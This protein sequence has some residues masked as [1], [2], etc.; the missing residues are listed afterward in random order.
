MENW[1]KSL[2]F[3]FLA[4]NLFALLCVSCVDEQEYA[5]GGDVKLAFGC[6]TL[7]FDTIFT[8]VGSTTKTVMVYNNEDKPILIERISLREGA[9]SFFKLNVD[10][11]VSSVVKNVEVGAKDSLYIF[12][13]VELNPNNQSNP[14][15]IEDAIEFDFNGGYQSVLLHAYGQDAYY[16]KPTHYLL[17]GETDTI[18]YSLAN[19]GGETAGVEVSG[20]EIRWKSDK[21][22]VIIGTCV[23]D[24]AFTLKL[25]ANTRVHLGKDSEFWVYKDGSLQAV[26]DISAPVVFQSTRWDA[27]YSY[28]AGQWGMLRFIAGSRDNQLENVIIKNNTIGILVDTCVN[29][30]PTLKM[31]NTRIENCSYI[32]LYARGARV[33]GE[34]VIVQ[35]CGNYTLALTLGGRYNFVHSTFYNSWRYSTRTKPVLILNDYYLDVNDAVQY[36]PIEQA[37]FYNCIVYGSLSEEELE[38]DLLQ[39]GLTSY[40]FEN[41]ILKTKKY[42]SDPNFVNCIFKDP[43]FENPSEGDLRPKA[44]SPAIGAGNGVWSYNIPYDIFGTYRPDPPTIGAIEYQPLPEEE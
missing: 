25:E 41:C 2:V 23:V 5:S 38:F 34:N 7:S 4:V 20:G 12:V 11:N 32:G 36:R 29:A 43:Q 21:P 16:H 35:N 44:T 19:E 39:G 1:C 26:G 13:R 40:R 24:S 30:S 3:G 18:H 17:G 10:G 15:L 28:T 31:R 27:H 42:A 33:E 22:H 8:T 6:D 9:N 14:L 37:N